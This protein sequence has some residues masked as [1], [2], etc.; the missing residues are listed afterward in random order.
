VYDD[1]FENALIG[2]LEIDDQGIVQRVNQR[3]CELRGLSA[4]EILGNPLGDLSLPGSQERHRRELERRLS[5]QVSLTPYQRELRR[6]DG[7]VVTTEVQETLLWKN[8]RVMGMRLASM[9]ITDRK[10]SEE[11]VVETASELK[12]LFQAFPDLFLRLDAE[13]KVLDCKGGNKQD[14]FLAPETFS[15]RRLQDIL[16]ANAARLLM[17]AAATVRRTN[18]VKILEYSRESDH[19]QQFY[20]CRMLPLYWDHVVAVLRNVTDGKAAERE[21][22]RYTEEL[23]IKNEELESALTAAREATKLKSQFLANMSHEIRTPMNGVLGMTDFLLGTELTSEQREYTESI[24]QSADCLLS[25]INDILDLSKIE[26]GKLRLER[27]PFH[28]GVTV[29]EIASQFAIRARAKGLDFRSVIPAN[30]AWMVAGDPGRVRQVLTNLLGNA[31]KFTDQGEVSIEMELLRETTESL[32]VRLSVRDTGPGIAREQHR[33]LF[34]SF[35]QLDGSNARKYAGTGLGLAISKQIVELLGGE[36]GVSSDLG[37]GSTFWFT[38]VFEKQAAEDLPDGDL[39]KVSLKDVRILI[40]GSPSVS[41]MAKQLVE[42]WGGRSLEVSSGQAIV[43]TLQEAVG[44]GSPFRLAL[45][46]IDLPDLN[47][48]GVARVIKSEPSVSDTLLVAMTSSP[49]R[50]D[51]IEL[52]QEGFAGYLHKPLQASTL[53][54]TLVEV[55][56]SPQAADAAAPAPLVTRHTLREQKLLRPRSASRVLLAEDNQ[57]NQRITL[58]L[59]EKLGFQ[60]DAVVNGREAVEAMASKDYALVLM[61]CQMPDMD[62]FEATA[63]IRNKERYGRHTPICALTANAMG[64]DRERCLAAGMDDYVCKPIG[65]EQLKKTIDQWVQ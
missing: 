23:K 21:L 40:A 59:L 2:Y 6:P 64:G 41:A 8:R 1:L 24:K 4:N 15:G 49:L 25:V 3:E 9:D 62:G 7:S 19:G 31:I 14:P 46:D 33:H 54:N 12:A 29:E 60:A 55:L 10:R 16:P 48:P 34:Q 61:D 30:L 17:E 58:R 51:G 18:A 57:V 52:R 44:Q 43:P 26:A 39:L 13:G 47:G 27:I 38:A 28:L 45:V 35:T 11:R 20:E 22:A 53:F 50:G 5:G 42:A 32:T 56:K 63:I 37:R 36:I 65:L